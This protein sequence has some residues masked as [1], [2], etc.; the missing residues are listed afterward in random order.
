MQNIFHG[1]D[2]EQPVLFSIYNLHINGSSLYMFPS[3]SGM[4]DG[5]TTAIGIVSVNLVL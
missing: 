4:M 2:D 5:F 1:T 3:R